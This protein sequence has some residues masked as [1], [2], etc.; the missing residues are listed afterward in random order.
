MSQRTAKKKRPAES[1]V[2]KHARQLKQYL[3]KRGPADDG[4]A[5]TPERVA[6]AGKKIEASIHYTQSGLPTG[7]F[8]WRI[9][10]IIDQLEKRGTIDAQEWQV[11]MRYMRHYVGSHGSGPAT[12][13]FLPY[14]DR[15]FQGMTPPERAL[16]FR[17]A[18]RLARHAV[19]PMFHAAL[20]WLEKSCADEEPLWRLGA[21]Y[22][23][24]LSK[25]QQ[26]AKASTILHCAISMLARH[27]GVAHRWAAS[28]IEE[29]TLRMR[30]E[31][32][33]IELSTGRSKK[34][35]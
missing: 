9:S 25:S 34:S 10:P 13:K 22:Y 14:Y 29:I 27:Y 1:A 5:P 4:G 18:N 31:R 28:E 11:A 15:G 33:D 19:D 32:V 21:E 3:E 16:A 23:P 24:H 30:Y 6:Q 35:A 2:E 20:D 17:Q 7:H 8:H 12:S 26:S